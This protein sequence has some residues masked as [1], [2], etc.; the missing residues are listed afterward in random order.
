MPAYAAFKNDLESFFI[1]LA[2]EYFSD[3]AKQSLFIDKKGE[4]KDS[5]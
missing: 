5:I 3:T 1:E 4:L 2:Q